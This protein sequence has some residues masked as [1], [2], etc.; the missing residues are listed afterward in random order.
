[1]KRIIG[2]LIAVLV[3]LFAIPVA[4]AAATLSADK[5]TVV[6]GETIILSGTADTNENIVI[7]ITDTAGNIIFF[8]GTKTDTNGN[9]STGFVV[10]SDMAAGKLTIT[11][12]SGNDVASTTVTVTSPP[13]TPKPTTAP[14]PSPSSTGAP[15]NTVT[16][17]STD[18]PR[19]SATPSASPTAGSDTAATPDT[20]TSPAPASTGAAEPKVVTPSEI[21]LD[22]KTGIITVVIDVVD[23]PD[24]TVAV[25]TPNGEL[26]YVS[27][28]VDG[29]L[30]FQAAQ[31]EIDINGEVTLIA[32]SDE[33][34]P[35]A[36]VT[37]NV[38]DETATPAIVDKSS[39]GIPVWLIVVIVATA[40]LVAG[41]ILWLATHRRKQK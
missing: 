34:T 30:T 24:G 18:E 8:D 15:A 37:V 7:K 3:I 14:T 9:F 26:L 31:D 39:N 13:Q 5:S 22:E 1:M 20:G 40:L 6:P 41:A 23:L 2:V 4:S 11:A 17:S 28:A 36:E 38:L 10:P 16:P 33:N 12:G 21:S 27:G 35:L 19:S 29:A 25:E 32:L